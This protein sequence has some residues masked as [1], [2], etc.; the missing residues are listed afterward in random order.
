MGTDRHQH[1]LG[2]KEPQSP[3][4]HVKL[5]QGLEMELKSSFACPSRENEPDIPLPALPMRC[6]LSRQPRASVSPG[7]V[8]LRGGS[9]RCSQR[10][11]SKG[12]FQHITISSVIRNELSLQAFL[13]RCSA[14]S[15]PPHA[16]STEI[17]SWCCLGMQFPLLGPFQLSPFCDSGNFTVSF[18]CSTLFHCQE[19]FLYMWTPLGP[20]PGWRCGG[21]GQLTLPLNCHP[22]LNS[23]SNFILF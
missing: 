12:R 4:S 17:T 7:G 1:A 21:S 2:L 6:K 10:L 14:E 3:A 13:P 18:G 20:P 23:A 15:S 16:P 8:M 9:A 19:K 22:T 5:F 11:W